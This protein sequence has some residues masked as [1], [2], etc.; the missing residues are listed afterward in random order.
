MYYIYNI[1]TIAPVD[2]T[3]YFCRYICAFRRREWLL[4]IS[5]QLNPVFLSEFFL[6]IVKLSWEF[7]LA[8]TSSIVKSACV[9]PKQIFVLLTPLP[10]P[11]WRSLWIL[12]FPL[13]LHL[14]FPSSP[15]QRNAY[16]WT[17][18]AGQWEEGPRGRARL[19]DGESRRECLNMILVP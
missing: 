5:F 13:L 1:N 19:R 15:E 14:F 17:S 2:G 4:T 11:E 7:C 16:W 8:S 3:Q 6:I 12:S 9:T 10:S 18:L